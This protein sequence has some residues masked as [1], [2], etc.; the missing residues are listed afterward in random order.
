MA[1]IKYASLETLTALVAQIKTLLNGKVDKVSGKGLSTNDLTNELK[2]H[3]DAAYTHSQAPHAPSDAER[4]V[5]I[6]VKVN[7][8]ALTPDGERAVDVDVPTAVSELTNDSGF[9]TST[10]VSSAISTAL[11]N[12]YTKTQTDSAIATA[13][14]DASH[15]KRQIVESLPDSN[16]DENTIYMLK[17]TAGAGAQ[18]AYDEFMWLNNA[19]EKIGDTAVD[20]SNYVTKETLT[21]TLADYVKVADM[22]AITTE[23]VQGLFTPAG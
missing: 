23:E 19:W 9:Q 16:Q 5:I 21:S 20:L 2:T 8:E 1:T 22:V 13:V 7:G 3:Y 14:A 17:K 11:G 10:Q 6:S 18:N 12:Y 15:L 4:N